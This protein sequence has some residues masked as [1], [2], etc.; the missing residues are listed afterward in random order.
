MT[1]GRLRTTPD[2]SQAKT[3]TILFDSGS[4]ES[5]IQKN[6]LGKYISENTTP[7]LWSTAGGDL[8]TYAKTKVE[9][10]LPEFYENTLLVWKMHVFDQKLNYDIIIGRDLM[11]EL[12]IKL[13][14]ERHRTRWLDVSIPMKRTE[15]TLEDFYVQDT[16]PVEEA[17]NRM[18]SILEA[19]YEPADLDELVSECD[20]LSKQEE[21]QM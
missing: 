21:Q 20:H 3:I 5:V 14:F 8:T 9:F 17:S 12:G 10:T 7:T 15:C 18:R 11:R 13:D 1:F 19:M 2:G 6:T 4:E 16:P